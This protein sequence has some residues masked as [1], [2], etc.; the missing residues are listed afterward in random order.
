M[1]AVF[2]RPEA[3]AGMA[4]FVL[5]GG[6]ARLQP[7]EIAARNNTEVW[8]RSGVKPGDRVI[9]YPPPAVRQDGRVRARN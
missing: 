7:V 1:S 6:R 4:V 9:I 3:N 5:I 2:P 8:V